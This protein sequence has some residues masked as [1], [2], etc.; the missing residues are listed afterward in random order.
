[1]TDGAW[2]TSGT[3][4]GELDREVLTSGGTVRWARFGPEDAPPVVLLHGTP[5]SSYVWRGP[6]AALA[7]EFR[8]H[9][10]DMPGYGASEMRTGQ[11]VTLASQARVFTE[12]LDHWGLAEPAVAAHD[13]GGC[14]AL[15]AHLLHGARYSRLALVDPVAL[16]PWGSAT[17]R[18]LGAHAEVFGEL[19]PALHEALVRA[20]LSSASHH[21][22][23]AHT[24][25]RLA[26]PWCTE[27]G[28]AAFYRQI[29]QNDQRF[30]DEIQGRYGELALPV[31]L[32]WGAEDT[33]IPPEKGRELAALI[34]G[35][36]LLPIEE[37]G[38][39]VQEDAPA[40]LTAALGAFLRTAS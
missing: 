3:H 22:L 9:L 16:A 28:R 10:W 37:A 20:Y 11:D 29:E 19:P 38:H 24:L 26:A 27:E 32:C 35:C 6:A 1:M 34:P 14:V 7:H 25:D 4:D 39:L 18:L 5:F 23:P 31:L 8:V 17:Y 40:E 2:T 36:T 21:G 33:W 30:T 15:R 13:F 12:L